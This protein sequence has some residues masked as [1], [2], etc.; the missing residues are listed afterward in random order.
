[1]LTP[2][3]TALEAAFILRA[4]DEPPGADL[5]DLACGF[6]RHA[7]ALAERGYRV[8]GLDF[9]H[10]YLERAEREAKRRNVGN[11]RF[12]LGDIRELRFEREF[13]GIYSYYSSFGYFDD[14]A[15]FAVLQGVARSLKPGGRFLIDLANRDG[16]LTRPQQRTWS[17]RDDGSLLMEEFTLDSKTSIITSRLVL[18]RPEGPQV[19]KEF[20]LRTYT[21]AE[22]SWLLNQAGLEVKRVWGGPDESEFT[23]ESRRL[24]LL[25]E[26]PTRPGSPA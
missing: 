16:V 11:V 3:Q 15:N 5:L 22:L 13:D 18:I 9:N 12:V 10:L 17:Q 4:L 14:A 6:G 24:I 2:E 25:A 8:T 1:V 19:H 23:A 7:L 21:C 26:A 20:Y